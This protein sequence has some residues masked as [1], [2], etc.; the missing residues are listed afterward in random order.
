MASGEV[1]LSYSRTIG[2]ARKLVTGTTPDETYMLAPRV[3]AV[4]FA[5]LCRYRAV[6]GTRVWKLVTSPPSTVVELTP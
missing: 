3:P 2:I 4:Q 5:P 1:Q 6:A